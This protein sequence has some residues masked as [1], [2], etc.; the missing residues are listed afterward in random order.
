M[1]VPVPV[2]SQTIRHHSGVVTFD[3]RL[4]SDLQDPPSSGE[5]LSPVDG[6]RREEARPNR[7]WGTR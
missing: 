4:V 1:T 7:P 6:V 3:E 2:L 5:D